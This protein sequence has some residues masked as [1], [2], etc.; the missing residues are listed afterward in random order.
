MKRLII[1][2]VILIVWTLLPI[3]VGLRAEG[4]IHVK[5]DTVLRITKIDTVGWK[6]GVSENK[7]MFSGTAW[8]RMKGKIVCDTLPLG[9][10]QQPWDWLVCD[11]IKSMMLV[12]VKHRP[13]LIPILGTV[14]VY[15]PMRKE[16]Q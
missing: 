5:V 6:I 7:H 10:N 4:T 1:V 11:T 12:Y 3:K 16:K 8:Y 2:I 13:I 15:E 9:S 14:T